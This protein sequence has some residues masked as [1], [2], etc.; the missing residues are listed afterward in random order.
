MGRD[1]RP[2]SRP[3]QHGGDP[4][5]LYFR[6]LHDKVATGD[7]KPGRRSSGRRRKFH[8]VRSPAVQC[9]RRIMK[10]YFGFVRN[11]FGGNVR[12]VGDNDV[13][14]SAA[15]RQRVPQISPDEFN[16]KRGKIL[17]R[18]GVR[19]LAEF[20][21]NNFS[22][23]NFVRNGSGNCTGT[24]PQ[25][26]HFRPNFVCADQ[27]LEPVDHQLN[28]RFSFRARDKDTRP[29]GELEVAEMCNA[30]NVLERNTPGALGHQLGVAFGGPG[31]PKEEGA[32]PPQPHIKQVFSQ[33][34]GVHAGAGDTRGGKNGRRLT[35]G[36]REGHVRADRRRDLTQV[37]PR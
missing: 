36:V 10:G 7:Q 25:I 34:L 18:P 15:L 35:D 28:H 31:I 4:A 27:R 11:R 23:W 13:E 33:Q 21:S 1:L 19:E 5:G 37:I 9:L 26:D 20:D 29:D 8:A 30:G 32:K 6:V 24:R 3:F 17:L 2:L 16:A 14:R 22:P 12:R